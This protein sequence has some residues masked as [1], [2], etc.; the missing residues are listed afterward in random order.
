VLQ[1]AWRRLRARRRRVTA[2]KA[3]L[4]PRASRR[5]LRNGRVA[6]KLRQEYSFPFLERL[7]PPP[8]RERAHAT[9]RGEAGRSSLAFS[10][11]HAAVSAEIDSYGLLAAV[12][13]PFLNNSCVQL[14]DIRIV[15]TWPCSRSS[16]LA[17]KRL[18]ASAESVRWNPLHDTSVAAACSDNTLSLLDMARTTESPDIVLG[19]SGC[20]A[21]ARAQPTR[22]RD[23]RFSPSA[24]SACIACASD[25]GT[26]TLF[27][28]RKKKPAVAQALVPSA[29]SAGLHRALS[30][31]EWCGSLCGCTV[32]G[33]STGGFLHAW[34]IRSMSSGP[35]AF[36]SGIRSASHVRSFDMRKCFQRTPALQGHVS[37]HRDSST[38]SVHSLSRSPVSTT[39]VGCC[40]G[41]GWAAALDLQHSA[42]THAYCPPE[43]QPSLTHSFIRPRGA[44]SISGDQFLFPLNE[45]K[46]T[47]EQ[48]PSGRLPEGEQKSGNEHSAVA[49][50]DCTPKISARCWVED[51]RSPEQERRFASYA[52]PTVQISKTPISIAACP[53]REGKYIVTTAD[54]GVSIL[55]L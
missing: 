32:I 46:I 33:S 19:N 35:V 21:H 47:D 36:G 45:G 44:W 16:S 43:V 48:S 28:S 55:S 27:D 23:C 40:I 17:L 10:S 13:C 3:S 42:L 51:K 41:N 53:K 6:L 38:F 9:L 50:M 18:N 7:H 8:P 12:S 4:R 11:R 2:F 34:D 29:E 14:L 22:M 54:A 30:A 39:A 1:S 31:V 49:V 37:T 26:L 25:N 15:S 20:N 5:Q 24:G 52:Q